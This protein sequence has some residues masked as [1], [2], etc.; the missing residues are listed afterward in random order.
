MQ[1]NTAQLM[2]ALG[3]KRYQYVKDA[4]EAQGSPEAADACHLMAL[5][6]DGLGQKQLAYKYFVLAYERSGAHPLIARNFARFLFA[7]K[8]YRA[9]LKVFQYLHAHGENGTVLSVARCLQALKD[10]SGLS[11]W[12]AAHHNALV[13]DYSG[14]MFLGGYYRGRDELLKA[15]QCY[16]QALA[17]SPGKSKGLTQVCLSS[18]LRLQGKSARALAVV[19]DC[20][21]DQE[22]PEHLD[23]KAGALIDLGRVDEGLALFRRLVEQYPNYVAGYSGYAHALWEYCDEVSAVK[24]TIARLGNDSSPDVV[25]AKAGFFIEAKDYA[26]ALDTLDCEACDDLPV[27][28]ALRA[29]IH[30]LQK[31]YRVARSW[32]ET[33]FQ[34]FQYQ[35]PDFIN[36][37]CRHLIECS[38][39][40]LAE[41]HLVALRQHFPLHQET[42]ANLS[43]CWRL[44]GDEREFLYCDYD[45]FVREYP[46]WGDED[47]EQICLLSDLLGGLHKA[48]REP[49]RQSLR[50]GSQTPGM[51]FGR[52]EPILQQ[53]QSKI[54]A[55][56]S[57]HSQY[58]ATVVDQSHPLFRH[59]QDIRFVSSWSV[60]LKP[61]GAHVNHIHPKGWLSS[62]FYIALPSESEKAA[63]GGCIQFGQPPEVLG[64]NL[65]P[66][67]VIQ[68]NVGN[69]V[70]FPSY[71]WHGTTPFYDAEQRM[72]VAFDVQ[73]D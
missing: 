66:R 9:A 65:P 27:A 29:N 53:L 57:A 62:A 2:Q 40:E 17:L 48:H 14:A 37:Y 63:G 7:A 71:M 72:T 73:A 3:A 41:R 1:P 11:E 32:Y 49:L 38:D 35:D 56:V 26:L 50:H 28:H 55:A 58:L 39:I 61:G 59:G 20:E 68:P 60:K 47:A 36:A 19:D 46:I 22:S 44:M 52:D 54:M 70:L 6:C 45:R 16:L 15:E 24:D 10:R 18:V 13:S 4:I 25:M 31:D 33:A 30:H 51:L 64:L 12:V 67:R 21:F 69:L 8:D 43:V 34:Q 23:C 42:I 5:A